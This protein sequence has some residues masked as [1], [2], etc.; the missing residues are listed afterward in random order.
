MYVQTIF[1]FFVAAHFI[2][3]HCLYFICPAL[4]WS[5]YQDWCSA[6]VV[7]NER[8]FFLLFDLFTVLNYISLSISLTLSPNPRLGYPERVWLNWGLVFVIYAVWNSA[9]IRM[10]SARESR[11]FLTRYFYISVLCALYCF[12]IFCETE[13]SLLL[14][15][16]HFN[17][18]AAPI[19][20]LF[21][22][23]GVH[24]AILFSW[25]YQTYARKPTNS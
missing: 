1:A 25:V 15:I 5:I 8:P 6:R 21:L 18:L 20:L 2:S 24:C 10:P 22:M 11:I 13:T 16:F 9:L 3:A 17:V 7:E 12:S 4:L 14:R 19:A 23:A